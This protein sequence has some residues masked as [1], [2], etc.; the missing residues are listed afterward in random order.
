MPYCTLTLVHLF[1]LLLVLTCLTLWFCHQHCVQMGL[2][3]CLYE[4]PTAD[5]G[6]VKWLYFYSKKSISSSLSNAELSIGRLKLFNYKSRGMVFPFLWGSNSSSKIEVNY[7]IWEIDQRPIAQNSKWMKGPSGIFFDSFL[8]IV[9]G[10]KVLIFD[11]FRICFSFCQVLSSLVYVR[12]GLF[13][14]NKW[15]DIFIS[16]KI[17]IFYLQTLSLNFQTWGILFVIAYC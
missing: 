7:S 3:A 5:I 10:T 8:D 2:F 15:T 4:Q 6:S 16:V 17:T 12:S 13:Y 14:R 1:V 11:I 9:Q